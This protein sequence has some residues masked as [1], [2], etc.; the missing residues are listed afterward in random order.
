MLIEERRN[1]ED[2]LEE[3]AVSKLN[4]LSLVVA[5]QEGSITIVGAAAQ[6]M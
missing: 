2:L 5:L 4:I 6:N 3:V 1:F